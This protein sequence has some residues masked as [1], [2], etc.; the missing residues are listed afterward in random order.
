MFG[1]RNKDKKENFSSVSYSQCGEDII[2][3]F[4]FRC[5]N[6]S[7]PVYLDIGAHHPYYLSNTAFFYLK[8]STGVNIEPD[9][10]LFEVIKKERPKDIN[11]NVGVS[12]TSG[13]SA[14]FYIM[15]VPTLNT[16]SKAEADRYAAYDGKKIVQVVKTPLQTVSSIIEKY[17]HNVSPNLVSID[18]EGMDMVIVRSFDFE[19]YK[20]E[21][22]CVETLT[23][24]ENNTEVKQKEIIKYIEDKG[25]LLFADTYMNSV[26]VNK[27]KW[28]RR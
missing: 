4:I 6:I 21:I 24:S 5:L 25:Y 7:K 20:P 8:G 10:Q 2:I 12:D 22:F 19:K 18:V 15:N 17:L 23:Y 16:F 28:S 1:A 3:D 9:P 11:L 26:F 13:S 14:D 27:E